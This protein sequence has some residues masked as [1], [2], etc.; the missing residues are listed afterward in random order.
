LK[1]IYVDSNI[2]V[3]VEVPERQHH[4]KS[5]EFME[6]VLGRR[7]IKVCTS[8]YTSLEVA[9]A[10]RRQKGQRTIYRYLYNIHIKYKEGQVMWLPPTKKNID[11]NHLVEK[12]VETAI[13]HA[14]PSGD[15]IHV[16]TM[17]E[18]RIKTLITWDKRD[19]RNVKGKEVFTPEEFL[20]TLTT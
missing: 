13:K 15:S 7:D 9:S 5:K 16:L 20:Q 11:F 1:K 2:F 6:R 10:L 3:D 14:T 18:H 8:I 4:L 17:V 12:L 19:F